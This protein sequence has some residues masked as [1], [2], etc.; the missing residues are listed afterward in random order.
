MSAGPCWPGIPKSGATCSSSRDIVLRQGH[1][2]DR[3]G[4]PFRH[5]RH[6]WPLAPL[7]E[8]HEHNAHFV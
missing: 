2:D 1:S 4:S 6:A 3:H 5:M 7:G 8:A